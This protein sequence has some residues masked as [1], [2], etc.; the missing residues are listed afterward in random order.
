MV[1]QKC[2][3]IYMVIIYLSIYYW[4][5]LSI[6]YCCPHLEHRASVKRF[7]HF[8]FLILDSRWDSLDRGSARRKAA[9]Y[10]QND[11]STE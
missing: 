9:T 3:Q 11:T 10:I 5:Y 2:H 1:G 8:S 4:L 7:F 6:Y